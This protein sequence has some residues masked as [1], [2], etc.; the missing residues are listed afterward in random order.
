VPHTDDEEV[1][2]L[3][4]A[5]MHEGE[6][7]SGGGNSDGLWK[8]NVIALTFHDNTHVHGYEYVYVNMCVTLLLKHCN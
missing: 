3:S 6:R 8:V 7:I 4:C 5:V 1:G 2:E